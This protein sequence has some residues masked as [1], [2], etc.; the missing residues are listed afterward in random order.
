MSKINNHPI[1][2][3]GIRGILNLTNAPKLAVDK[4]IP[5][6]II[7]A[8]MKQK[9]K[10]GSLF[11]CFKKNKGPALINTKNVRNKNIIFSIPERIITIEFASQRKGR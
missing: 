6:A 7:R 4:P 3:K 8:K 10:N 9:I 2:K 5:I 11:S 1:E